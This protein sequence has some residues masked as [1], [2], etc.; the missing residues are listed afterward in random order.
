MGEGGG[1]NNG[2]IMKMADLSKE[3]AEGALYLKEEI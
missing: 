2:P 3:Q 1:M